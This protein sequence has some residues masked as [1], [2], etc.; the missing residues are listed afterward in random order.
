MCE[1]HLNKY[2]YNS[3]N[4]RLHILLWYE[5]IILRKKSFLLKKRLKNINQKILFFSTKF[6]SYIKMCKIKIKETFSKECWYSCTQ[7][8]YSRKTEFWK[9]FKNVRSYKK[10]SVLLDLVYSSRKKCNVS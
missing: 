8:S 10:F 9:K 6:N 7:K 1:Y 3:F 4:L 2:I 5:A